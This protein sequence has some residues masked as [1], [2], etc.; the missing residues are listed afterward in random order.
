M[1]RNANGFTLI[2]LLMVLGV[3]SVLMGMLMPSVGAIREKAQRMATGQKLRQIGLAVSTYQSITGRSL[4]AADL[5]EWMAE[6]ASET[7]LREGKIYIHEEDALLAAVG[8]SIPLVVVRPGSEGDWVPIDG[9]D[10]WPI[11]IAVASGVGPAVNP[12]STPIVWTRG[13]QTNGRWAGFADSRPGVY[14]SEGGFI[15]FLDGHVEF[16]NDLNKEGGQLIH[17]TEGTP[18]GDIQEAL[19][20][21]AVVYDFLGRVF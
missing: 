19:P 14:G 21:G 5:G 1:K 17:Y 13:L 8:E 12:S 4:V 10:R 6:L 18:T 15:A 20:P 3:M 11:G 7:G 9:F 2:E 16:Y